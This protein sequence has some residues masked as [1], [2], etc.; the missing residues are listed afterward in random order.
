MGRKP[1]YALPHWQVGWHNCPLPWLAVSTLPTLLAVYSHVFPCLFL[2]CPWIMSYLQPVSFILYVLV[3]PATP[4]PRC[5]RQVIQLHIV[6]FCS[7]FSVL[8]TVWQCWYTFT[9]SLLSSVNFF[10]WINLLVTAANCTCHYFWRHHKCV[11]SIIIPHPLCT[12][13]T[14]FAFPNVFPSPQSRGNY[15][16]SGKKNR[17]SA[18]FRLTWLSLEAKGIKPTSVENQ[19]C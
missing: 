17:Q 8:H 13:L 4:T 16:S 12:F 14:M 3:L 9:T 19:G 2:T 15:L 1:Y 18:N 5:K 11:A 6:F 10:V 7:I